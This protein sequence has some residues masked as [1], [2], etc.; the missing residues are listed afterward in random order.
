MPLSSRKFGLRLL[1]APGEPLLPC[2][3]AGA[4]EGHLSQMIR[5]GRGYL[6]IDPAAA[7]REDAKRVSWI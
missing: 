6:A 5:S 4:F 1:I 2:G 7:S 3:G